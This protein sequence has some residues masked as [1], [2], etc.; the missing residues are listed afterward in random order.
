MK[1]Y[2][3]NLALKAYVVST[4]ALSKAGSV[5]ETVLLDIID[6]IKYFKEYYVWPIVSAA[7]VM[8]SIYGAMH[9]TGRA[10]IDD[11]GAIVGYMYNFVG[12]MAAAIFTVSIDN[13]LFHDLKVKEWATATLGEKILDTVKTLIVL[14]AA[15]L[16]MRH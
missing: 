11:P 3:Y 13:H 12:L 15:M 7:L 6:H 5:V 4:S 2:L 16:F 1:D 8:V 14:I 10:V 9:L